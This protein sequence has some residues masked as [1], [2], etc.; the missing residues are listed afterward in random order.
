MLNTR[1][2]DILVDY[3]INDKE[4]E[5]NTIEQIKDEYNFDEIKDA[6]DNAAGPHQLDFLMAE[7]TKIL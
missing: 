5:Q 7:T 6:F 3:F 2:E 4:I 1:A